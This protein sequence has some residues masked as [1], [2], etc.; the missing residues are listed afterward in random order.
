L[1][2]CGARS[3]SGPRETEDLIK[4]VSEKTG[5]QGRVKRAVAFVKALDPSNFASI[6]LDESKDVLVEL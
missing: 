3:Y 6:A 5:F 1:L 2:G 4:F